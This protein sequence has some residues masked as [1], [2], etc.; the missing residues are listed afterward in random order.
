MP[1]STLHQTAGIPWN[2][3]VPV[4]SSPVPR[5]R[6]LRSSCEMRR[7]G[8]LPRI[9]AGAFGDNAGS[10]YDNSSRNSRPISPLPHAMPSR[11]MSAQSFYAGSTYVQSSYAP[12]TFSL[13]QQPPTRVHRNSYTTARTV[14]SAPIVEEKQQSRTFHLRQRSKSDA[15]SVRS[16]S[17]VRTTVDAP[18]LLTTASSII[19]AAAASTEPPP[20]PARSVSRLNYTRPRCSS[21]QSIYDDCNSFASDQSDDEDFSNEQ[22]WDAQHNLGRLRR[23]AFNA[24]QAS[25]GARSAPAPIEE[26]RTRSKRHATYRMSFSSDLAARAGVFSSPPQ[27]SAAKIRAEY[28]AAQQQQTGSGSRVSMQST[29]SSYGYSASMWSGEPKPVVR[30]TCYEDWHTIEKSLQHARETLDKLTI[31]GVKVRPTNASLAN[32][33]SGAS[34][35][36]GQVKARR[37]ANLFR[38]APAPTVIKVRCD[39]MFSATVKR[40]ES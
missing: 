39:S 21:E 19:R 12:S 24:S 7:S 15:G 13:W 26:R 29:R 2:L 40:L 18:A 33:I 14:G 25:L 35:L 8:S 34:S 5:G 22:Q 17:T 6:S 32:S 16:F 37:L 9:H 10:I 31:Q 11:P 3:S 30:A 23:S 28:R 20:R 27:S 1:T 4:P 38:K 36:D